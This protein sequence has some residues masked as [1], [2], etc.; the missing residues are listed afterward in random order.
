MVLNIQ[1]NFRK[2]QN[3]VSSDNQKFAMTYLKVIRKI[4]QD[5]SVYDE[6]GCV[7]EN[8]FWGRF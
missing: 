2:R 5:V 3:F 1:D 6:T 8:I 7:F 4:R